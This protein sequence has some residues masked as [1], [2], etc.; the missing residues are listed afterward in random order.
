[1]GVEGPTQSS[2]D[3]TKRICGSPPVPLPFFLLIPR[4]KLALFRFSAGGTGGTGGPGPGSGSVC[5]PQS[6]LKPWSGPLSGP[7]SDQV[8]TN[9]V[10]GSHVIE[11]LDSITLT[12][13]A[14]KI[15]QPLYSPS[16][17][18]GK[19]KLGEIKVRSSWVVRRYRCSLVTHLYRSA[20]PD[21]R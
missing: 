5:G 17:P 13:V 14:A 21:V 19:Y 7:R 6:P 11:I 16:R 18:P 3:F 10:Y 20:G 9:Q 15:R 1:M 8:P 2:V 12:R 4:T